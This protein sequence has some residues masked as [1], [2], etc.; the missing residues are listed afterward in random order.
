MLTLQKYPLNSK[1]IFKKEINLCQTL[2]AVQA[3]NGCFSEP[4]VSGA[5]GSV[6]WEGEIK[7]TF[8][9]S[10][11]MNYLSACSIHGEGNCNPLQS[12]CL[13]NSM[14]RGA[15]WATVHGVPKSWTQLSN[16]HNTAPY[17]PSWGPQ[18]LPVPN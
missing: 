5:V 3:A 8:L 4:W 1:H 16:E 11:L 17:K 6:K 18:R 13:E 14:D 15:W 7:R 9:P 10:C 12:S 2:Q